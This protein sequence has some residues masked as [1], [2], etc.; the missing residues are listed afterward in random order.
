[1]R[2]DEV[3]V[4]QFR[5]LRFV[6]ISDLMSLGAQRWKDDESNEG[7][8]KGRGKKCKKAGQP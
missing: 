3:N 5:H 6:V 1:M 4:K 8:L 2:R 7:E